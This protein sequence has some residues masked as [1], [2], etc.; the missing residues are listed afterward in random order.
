[1]KE[2]KEKE[3]EQQ[4]NWTSMVE[5]KL[6]NLQQGYTFSICAST[7]TKRKYG[8]IMMSAVLLEN[9]VLYFGSRNVIK[10][11]AACPHTGKVP[12][13]MASSSLVIR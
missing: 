11:I 6:Q 4:K 9:I 8:M 3:I 13:M 12:T 1:M 10:I 7:K 5:E 2:E